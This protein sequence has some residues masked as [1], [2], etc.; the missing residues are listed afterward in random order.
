MKIAFAIAAIIIG[1]VLAWAVSPD[2]TASEVCADPSPTLQ[3]SCN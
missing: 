1:G 2:G 3:F